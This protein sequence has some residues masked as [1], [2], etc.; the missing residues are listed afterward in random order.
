VAG[1]LLIGTAALEY[2]GVM[3][4]DEAQRCMAVLSQPA[5]KK[6]LEQLYRQTVRRGLRNSGLKIAARRGSA[7]VSE[8]IPI[9]IQDLAV[10]GPAAA[11]GPSTLASGGQNQQPT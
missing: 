11:K 5:D 3:P 4:R 7:R 1:N 9:P 10:D 6:A 8:M 2:N